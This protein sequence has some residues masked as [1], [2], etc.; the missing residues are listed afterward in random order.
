MRLFEEGFEIGKNTGNYRIV[1]K[2]WIR[3]GKEEKIK[4]EPQKETKFLWFKFWESIGF[5]EYAFMDTVFV[6]Y[7]MDTLQEAME[8][9][10]NF[11]QNTLNAVKIEVVYEEK[12]A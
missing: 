6:P 3:H 7:S 10:N 8:I 4:F 2:T 1:K 12:N 5:E 11:K 9:I